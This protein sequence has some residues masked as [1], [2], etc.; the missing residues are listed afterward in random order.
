MCS[1]EKQPLV[2]NFIPLN[3]KSLTGQELPVRNFISP[4]IYLWTRK[5]MPLSPQFYS[6]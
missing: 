6:R 1:N 5:I 2:R 4:E 3:G